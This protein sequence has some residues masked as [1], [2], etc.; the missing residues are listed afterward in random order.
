MAHTDRDNP[1]LAAVAARDALQLY[2]L[3]WN[4]SVDIRPDD[5]VQALELANER[6]YLLHACLILAD[7]RVSPEPAYF[8]DLLRAAKRGDVELLSD[9]LNQ[10]YPVFSLTVRALRYLPNK[11]AKEQFTIALRI[12]ARAG[13]FEAVQLLLKDDRTNGISALR[14]LVFLQDTDAINLL[15]TAGLDPSLED[16]SALKCA[17]Q[18]RDWKMIKLLAQDFRTLTYGSWFDGCPQDIKSYLKNRRIF[19]FFRKVN[20]VIF[21]G[22]VRNFLLQHVVFH[23]RSKYIL[24]LASSFHDDEPPAKKLKKDI[25]FSKIP[26]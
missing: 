11:S 12:A 24:R 14:S 17:V 3:L 22:R 21:E 7:P 19:A 13:H 15:I 6:G 18:F 16:N 23:P 2:T 25:A 5:L 10:S 9:L 26:Y 1:F 20:K 4:Q 8:Q